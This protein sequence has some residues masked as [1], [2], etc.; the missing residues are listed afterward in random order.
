[1]VAFTIS[2]IWVRAPC[3]VAVHNSKSIYK[4]LYS[5]VLDVAR[6]LM[7]VSSLIGLRLQIV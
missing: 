7:L 6:P 1:M 2:Q 3:K 5:I 4:K